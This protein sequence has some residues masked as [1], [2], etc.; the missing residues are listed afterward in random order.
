VW[1]LVDIISECIVPVILT[2]VTWE[3]GNVLDIASG[4]MVKRTI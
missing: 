1:S 3:V 4:N 2:M